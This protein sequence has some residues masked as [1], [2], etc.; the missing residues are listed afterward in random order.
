[1]LI[2][3]KPCL[4]ELLTKK[5]KIINQQT[6]QTLNWLVPSDSS[7]GI[8]LGFRG[9]SLLV[10]VSSCPQGWSVPHIAIDPESLK[11]LFCCCF[12]SP[13]LSPRFALGQTSR[14]SEFG[15]VQHFVLHLL[16]RHRR[17]FS[18]CFYFHL[19]LY[20]FTFSVLCLVGFFQFF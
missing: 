12:V 9:S 17:S 3:A 1:M 8:F 13:S 18:F 6:L 4:E 15:S 16:K 20:F 14:P 2:T 7:H 5:K 11:Q 10:P 19:L